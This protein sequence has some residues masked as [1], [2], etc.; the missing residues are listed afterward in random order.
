MF[1]SEVKHEYMKIGFDLLI[2]IVGLYEINYTR[3]P[4][5]QRL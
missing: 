1:G 2:L 5:S 3:P 4:E